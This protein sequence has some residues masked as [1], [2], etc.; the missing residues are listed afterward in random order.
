VDDCILWR[1]R[2]CRNRALQILPVEIVRVPEM[3]SNLASLRLRGAATGEAIHRHPIFLS[4]QNT[5]T[6]M[7]FPRR[8]IVARYRLWRSYRLCTDVVVCSIRGRIYL[9]IE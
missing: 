9:W 3:N 8:G 2:G 6:P 5:D 1:S 7:V 4:V